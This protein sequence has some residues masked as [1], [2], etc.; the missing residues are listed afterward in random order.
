M[1]RDYKS[2]TPP[3]GK[4]RPGG[5]LLIGIFIGLLLG[6][7]IAVGI[8][9]YMKSAPIP[10][11]TK[12]KPPEK[13]ANP[14]LAEPGS[15][16]PPAVTAPAGGVPPP[17]GQAQE[18]PHFDFY[19]ILPGTEEPVTEQQI[20]QAATAPAT[21]E[22]GKVIYFLQAGSF[23]ND[24]DA[25]NL[26]ARLALIGVEAAVQSADVGDKGI[27]YRV[28]V[29]PYAK[30]DDTAKLRQMLAQNGIEASLIKVKDFPAH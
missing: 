18:K 6:L 28:R 22:S 13:S 30:I 14:A 5:S 25:E 2:K 3:G 21:V 17:V 16:A 19:K 27:W 12:V 1:S 29:G 26:K 9:W 24:A 8:A 20:K 7:G 23:Q 15:T 10:F 11:L 4:S